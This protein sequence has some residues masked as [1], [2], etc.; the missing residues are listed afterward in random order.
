MFQKSASISGIALLSE[1]NVF[2]GNVNVTFDTWKEAVY[3]WKINLFMIQPDSIYVA[4]KQ[5]YSITSH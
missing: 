5:Y 4:C 2:A 3:D 1:Y